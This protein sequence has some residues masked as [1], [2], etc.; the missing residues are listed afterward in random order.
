MRLFPFLV[1]LLVVVTGCAQYTTDVP[2]TRG[3]LEGSWVMS[4]IA[5]ISER[6]ENRYPDTAPGLFIF[7]ESHYSMIWMPL[8]LVRAE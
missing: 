7:D 6:G 1:L 3:P 4:E 5:A 2:E 8:R